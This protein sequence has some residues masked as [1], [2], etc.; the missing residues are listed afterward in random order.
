MENLYGKVFAKSLN[1]SK[2]LILNTNRECLRL[3]QRSKDL[4][5]KKNTPMRFVSYKEMLKQSK[6]NKVS[7][8]DNVNFYNKSKL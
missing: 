3:R 4:N 6:K 5:G 8:I 2:V 1:G 7:V